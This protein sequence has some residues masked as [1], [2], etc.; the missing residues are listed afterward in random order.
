[1]EGI[2]IF[3][4]SFVSPTEIVP[5]DENVVRGITEA[6]HARGVFV[7]AHPSNIPGAWAAINGGVDIFAHTVPLAGLDHDIPKVMVDRGIALI[8]TLKL[9]RVEGPRFGQTDYE[10]R[11]TIGLAQAQL[12][13]FSDLG[14]EVMFGTDVG[15]ITDFDPTLEYVYMQ[16]AGLTFT[17]ILK[18]LTTTP[19]RRFGLDSHTGTLQGRR[20]RPGSRCRRAAEGTAPGRGGGGS[21]RSSAPPSPMGYPG[22][23]WHG[24]EAQP[25]GVQ[26]HRGMAQPVDR[27]R[28]SLRL[29]RRC[30]PQAQLGRCSAF[31]SKRDVEAKNAAARRRN[32]GTP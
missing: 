8:P 2:K 1:M 12:K 20:A 31:K 24:L 21:P 15:Y 18:S 16:D 7:V 13:V 25:D 11:Q 23:V 30:R 32:C 4:G 10:I 28:V 26:A 3:T 27:G 6:A 14:G 5:M 29:P 9:Y 19:S 17:D 22:I